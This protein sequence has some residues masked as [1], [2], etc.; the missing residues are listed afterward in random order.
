[1][2]RKR[3]HIAVPAE[4]RC[5]AVALMNVRVHNHRRFDRSVELQTANSNSH[6]MNYAKTLAMVSVR[7]MEAAADTRRPGIGKRLLPRE[8]R[9]ACSEPTSFHKFFRIGNLH[10]KNFGVSERAV[11]E[12]VHI[13]LRMDAQNICVRRR[14]RRKKIVRNRELVGKER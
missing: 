10:A 1:M 13:V 7:M 2:N 4:N 8:D 9:A 14:L 11:L 12:F 3:K 6:I 5:R